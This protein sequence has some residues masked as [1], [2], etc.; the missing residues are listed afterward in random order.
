MKI[1]YS[2]IEVYFGCFQHF[3]SKLHSF[4]TFVDGHTSNYRKIVFFWICTSGDIA[5]LQDLD[6]VDVFIKLICVAK[7]TLL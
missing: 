5:Y 4:S 7:A 3:Y 6:V 1:H 2:E